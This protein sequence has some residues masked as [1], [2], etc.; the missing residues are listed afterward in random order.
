MLRFFSCWATLALLCQLAYAAPNAADLE[1][2]KNH[3]KLGRAYYDQAAYGRALEQ[4]KEAYRLSEKP[5]LL[6]RDAA[7]FAVRWGSLSPWRSL[8]WRSVRESTSFCPGARSIAVGDTVE[9]ALAGR[10]EMCYRLWAQKGDVFT[11]DV[12]TSK[13]RND[14]LALMLYDRQGNQV[15]YATSDYYRKLDPELDVSVDRSGVYFVKLVELDGRAASFSLASRALSRSSSSSM[16]P[17]T[18]TGSGT[19]SRRAAR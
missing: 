2:A 5:E 1:L 12:D 11:L 4:F 17:Q 10:G 3:F 13:E 7:L 8:G 15:S 18:R 14:Y 9:G 6:Y 19:R 16:T